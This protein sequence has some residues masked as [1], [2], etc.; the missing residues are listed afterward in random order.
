MR[1]SAGGASAYAWKVHSLGMPG[2]SLELVSLIINGRR[3]EVESNELTKKKGAMEAK[4]DDPAAANDPGMNHIEWTALNEIQRFE[5]G[6]K[7]RHFIDRAVRF[8]RDDA[9]QRDD[10]LFVHGPAGGA[11]DCH[12]ITPRAQR[13]GQP[14][15]VVLHA[16]ALR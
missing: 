13:A 2:V 12:R 16:S 14:D 8:D 7:E 9:A 15:N 11:E 5:R 3:L 10:A 4:C 6:R 1:S